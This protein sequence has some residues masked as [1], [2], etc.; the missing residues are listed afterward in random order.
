MR[1]RATGHTIAERDLGEHTRFRQIGLLTGF[2]VERPL[3]AGHPLLPQAIGGV[4]PASR[5][6]RK[7]Q[8]SGPHPAHAEKL[9]DM[10]PTGQG[11]DLTM[12]A[13][14]RSAVPD[15]TRSNRN[16]TRG[17]S[18]KNRPVHDGIVRDPTAPY[19]SIVCWNDETGQEL[20]SAGPTCGRASV[21]PDRRDGVTITVPNQ[22]SATIAAGQATGLEPQL[23]IRL[24]SLK[25]PF[26][27]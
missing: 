5:T 21:F 6:G 10:I 2:N 1:R 26:P 11:R 25:R 22:S 16:S 7:L 8:A 9:P 14:E 3:P 18:G 24:P 4:Q 15:C 27:P 13:W 20:Q 17:E 19:G 12:P 23:I